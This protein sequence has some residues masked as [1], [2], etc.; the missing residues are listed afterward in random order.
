RSAGRSYF[1][2]RLLREVVFA[3]APLTGSDPR[4]EK[5][6]TMVR[7]GAAAA[8]VL[9]AVGLASAWAVS[10]ANNQAYVAE[11]G[12]RIAPVTA[13][14]EKVGVA[15]DAGVLPVLPVLDA[16]RAVAITSSAESNSVPWSMSFGLY[17]GDKL[18]AAVDRTYTRLLQDAFLPRLNRRIEDLLR[19]GAQS[20]EQVYE[21]LKAYLMLYDPA[22][23]EPEAFK[24][25]V[26]DDWET[27]LAQSLPASQ[28]PAAEAHL[29]AMLERHRELPALRVDADL[30]AAAR[31]KLAG[32]TITERIYQRLRREG[33]GATAPEFTISHKVGAA[34]PLVFTRASG[35]PLT[36]GVPGLYTLAGYQA[37]EGAVER[38]SQVFADEE[39]WVLGVKSSP[40]D[41]VRKRQVADEVRRLYLEDYARTWQEFVKDIRLVRARDVQGSVNLARV[42]SA[43]DSPLP[44]LLRAIVREVT[45]VRREDA[46]K[47]MIERGVDLGAKQVEKFSSKLPGKSG[48]ST[49]R[50]LA[51]AEQIVD[52]RFED[53]RAF[54]RGAEG[55]A[56]VDQVAPLMQEIY[57]HL[58]AVDAAQKKKL[59]PPESGAPLKLKG[60]A[61]SMPEP[62]RGA[63]NELSEVALRGVQTQTRANLTEKLSQIADF[64]TRA[65]NGRYPF[66]KSSDR[67][68]TQEDFGRLFAPGGLFDEFIQ[69][70]LKEHVDVGTRPWTFRRIAD[71]VGGGTSPA[72]IQLQRSQLIRDVFFRSGGKGVALR[73]DFKPIEMD[74]AITQFL[75]DVDGQIVRYTHGPQQPMPIQWPGPRGSS[76]VRLQI[77]PKRVGAEAGLVFEGP[78]A[79]FRLLDRAQIDTGPQPERFKVTFNV[80][81]RKTMFEVVASSVQNPFRFRE[82]EQFECPT[83]L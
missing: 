55:K 80:D 20:P 35:K 53:L 44:V 10:Y 28:R 71:Q 43:S 36:T 14:V 65:I 75:L 54:V 24:R 5:R 72:L 49:A 60:D 50:E 31:S 39:S 47:S 63:L 59:N 45:L 7:Y 37:F 13:L 25:F 26:M 52:A 12:A 40:L 32:R 74:A 51:S 82:L 66:V 67:D 83:R 30:V 23:M 2:Q 42:L 18:N 19:A 69:R 79:L 33:V 16:V 76:Q 29:N 15:P 34:A 70:E 57:A 8:T 61:A 1:L 46:D 27:N 58:L 4:W 68:V 22:R 73:F 21:A 64:C 11:V 6:R 41:L 17:Q 78:W 62:V 9:V 81:N 56:P 3:E 48:L 77:E 38:V